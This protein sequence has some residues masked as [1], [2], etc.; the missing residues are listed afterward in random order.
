M[1]VALVRFPEAAVAEAEDAGL[2]E[3]TWP[4]RHVRWE[5]YFGRTHHSNGT[6]VGARM[7]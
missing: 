1:V 7:L 2:R 5:S 4:S 6:I 3:E